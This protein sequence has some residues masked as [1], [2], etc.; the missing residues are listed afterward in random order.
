MEPWGR[1]HHCL[2]KGKIHYI[3]VLLDNEEE[4]PVFEGRDDKNTIEAERITILV[5][6]GAPGVLLLPSLQ[7]L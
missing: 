4:S 1:G 2:G 7:L 3:E 6:K 5:Q